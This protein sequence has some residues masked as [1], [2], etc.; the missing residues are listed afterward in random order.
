MKISFSL[1]SHTFRVD[2]AIEWIIFH[3]WGAASIYETNEK[4]K[5]GKLMSNNRAISQTHLMAQSSAV[6]PRHVKCREERGWG[7]VMN[8]WRHSSSSH[9][10]NNMAM[11]RLLHDQVQEFSPRFA[12]LMI[13]HSNASLL[14]RRKLIQG[15][16]SPKSKRGRLANVILIRDPMEMIMRAHWLVTVASLNST[17]RRFYGSHNLCRFWV[18]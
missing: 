3:S 12:R 17:F 2:T 13:N 6:N 15:A 5:C 7:E 4:G 16:D 8:A 9:R 14:E 18:R 1:F 11:N 10:P